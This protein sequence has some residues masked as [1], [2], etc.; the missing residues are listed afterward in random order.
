MPA[1]RTRRRWRLAGRYLLLSALAVLILFPLYM[2][3]VQSLF[4]GVD[5]AARPPLLYPP[6]PQWSSYPDAWT[7]GHLSTYLWNSCIVTVCIMLGQVFTSITAAYAFAFLHFPFKRTIFVLFLATM[8]IPLEVVFITNVV[9]VTSLGWYNTYAGL[10]VP[11]LATGFG[12]F[13]LR[14][15]F[16][17]LPTDLR[18]AAALDGYG[19]VRFLTRVA[20]PLCRPTV[21]ALAVLGFLG[22]WNQYLWPLVVTKDDSMR[23]VQI[24]LKQLTGTSID[25]FN[26]TSAG[27]VLAFVPIVLILILF[28]KQ[29]VRGL[30]AGA[31]KG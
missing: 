14:Q 20:L 16:L 6:S 12:A 27:V 4:R 9:T 15:S 29:L 28:Q 19:H 23:T 21:A 24:G 7:E 31:V 17:A 26:V 25:Q 18:D 13:L 2:V 3:V 22:A 10:V 11:S 1:E 30:T 8:M 5:F